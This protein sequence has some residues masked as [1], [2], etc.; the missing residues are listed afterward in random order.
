MNIGYSL[1]PYF[2]STL[3]HFAPQNANYFTNFT[4]ECRNLCF[5]LENTGGGKWSEILKQGQISTRKCQTH[6]KAGYFVADL[7]K[8]TSGKAKRFKKWGFV[9]SIDPGV[10]PSALE[11][12]WIAVASLTFGLELGCLTD[13]SSW[14][15]PT[16]NRQ[17]KLRIQVTQTRKPEQLRRRRLLRCQ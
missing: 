7:K 13:S 6:R 9:E 10:C 11:R 5:S 1:L 3:L 16:L 2:S 8:R 15:W 14:N 12:S 4:S 17:A